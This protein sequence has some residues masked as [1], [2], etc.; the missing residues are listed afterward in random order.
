[1]NIFWRSIICYRMAPAFNTSIMSKMRCSDPSATFFARK[2]AASTVP[3]AYMLLPQTLCWKTN[4]TFPSADVNLRGMAITSGTAGIEKVEAKGTK[5]PYCCWTKHAPTLA[6][7]RLHL[8][9]QNCTVHSSSA[10]PALQ[11]AT[12]GSRHD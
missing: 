1:M 2:S 8:A 6:G 7:R 12:L 4:S 11:E 3:S 10:K 9:L 5:I